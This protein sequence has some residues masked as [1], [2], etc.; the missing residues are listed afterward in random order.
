MMS[1]ATT[2]R[3]FQVPKAFACMHSLATIVKCLDFG[4]WTEPWLVNKVD[5]TISKENS[6][7]L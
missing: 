7:K 3:L 2:G 5:D 4:I 1:M 6:N